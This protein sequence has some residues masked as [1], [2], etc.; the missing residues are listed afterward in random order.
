ME[1]ATWHPVWHCPARWHI[2]AGVA[3]RKSDRIRIGPQGRAVIPAHLRRQLDLQPGDTVAVRVEAGRLVLERREDVLERLQRRFD[4]VPRGRS[5]AKE[6][7][8]ER[9]REARNEAKR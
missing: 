9:R 3:Q 7:L 5:L 1:C 8:A 4:A 2:I 6:L